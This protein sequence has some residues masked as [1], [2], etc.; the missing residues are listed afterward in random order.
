MSE[1]PVVACYRGLESAGAV[2][3]GAQLARALGEPLV[4][5]AAY[6]YEPACLSA[7]AL[8]AEDNAR[9]ASAA[10]AALHRARTFA[11]AGIEVREEVVPADGIAHTLVALARGVDAGMIVVGRDT[12]GHVMRSLL[13][14]AP[15]LIAVAA[16]SIP[17]ARTDPLTRIGVAYDGSRTAQCALLAAAQLALAVDARLVLLTAGPT[18]EQ[19]AAWLHVAR[20]SVQTRA[21]PESRELVGGA[22]AQLTAASA[23]LDL[24]VCGSRGRGRA[25]GTVLGSVSAHLVTHAQCPVLVV[26]PTVVGSD[27]D[28]LGFISA[29]AA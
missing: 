26:P 29:A 16:Q 20:L 7:R 18:R 15:C 22:P 9:R 12:T 25:L 4:L 11:G 23:D 3:L 1:H 5:A 14:R 6:P 21:D 17:Q 8:P 10:H 19:A 27:A 13:A 28:R 2:Q 24:L